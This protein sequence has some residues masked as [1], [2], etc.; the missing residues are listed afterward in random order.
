ME[1]LTALTPL[2]DLLTGFGLSTLLEFSRTSPEMHHILPI[3]LGILLAVGGLVAVRP[4]TPPAWVSLC[5]TTFSLIIT[6][7]LVLNLLS[8][9]CPPSGKELSLLPAYILLCIPRMSPSRAALVLQ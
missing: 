2:A 5:N 6:L 1:I 8:Q 9:L 3:C 7:S 4:P